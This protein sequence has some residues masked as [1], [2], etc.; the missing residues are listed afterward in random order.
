[1]FRNS[2][3]SK[4]LQESFNVIQSIQDNVKGLME[5]QYKEVIAKYESLKNN[6]INLQQDY[7]KSLQENLI[8]K[9]KIKELEETKDQKES[10]T[11]D[12][13]SSL[14]DELFNE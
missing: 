5:Q 8:L 1:M 11:I 4:Q 6:F 3:N 9:A 14:A 7:A 12:K 13:Y 10:E 2:L